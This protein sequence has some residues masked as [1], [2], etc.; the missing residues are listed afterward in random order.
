MP[1]I[2][3][4]RVGRIEPDVVDFLSMA[5]PDLFA[6]DCRLSPCVVDPSQAF[7]QVRQQY[8]S[9]DVLLALSGV[10]SRAGDKVLGLTPVD[11]F[12][13]ILTFVFGQA[14]L[15]NRLAVMSTYRLHQRFY[16]LPEDDDLLLRRCEKEAV[17]ELG[18][19][20]GLVHCS[21]FDCVMHF[22]NSVDEVDLKSSAFCPDCE[23]ALRFAGES[24]LEGRQGG[25]GLGNRLSKIL[26]KP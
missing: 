17:H 26:D 1:E 14:Q 16:G 2:H 6:L 21:T 4:I 13:P 24:Q 7:N 11:L 3:L 20:F 25:R 5:L 8:N 18:H 19:T 10:Q 23:K 9:M 22:S 12:I 15:N